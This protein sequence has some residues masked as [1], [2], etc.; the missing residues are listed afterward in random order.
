MT[1][2][3]ARPGGPVDPEAVAELFIAGL[4][5]AHRTITAL[6]PF[7]PADELALG[8][9]RAAARHA[10]ET[11]GRSEGLRRAQH[12]V[13]DWALQRYRRDGFGAAYLTGWLD[14]PDRRLELVSVLVDAVTAYALV[15]VLPDETAATLVARLDIAVGGPDFADSAEP[16]PDDAIPPGDAPG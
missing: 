13:A 3:D 10:A 4:E 15:D 7:P 9:A 11:V 1:A 6:G 16:E 2:P 14:D 8:E 5:R 12:L